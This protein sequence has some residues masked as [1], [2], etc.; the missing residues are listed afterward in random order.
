MPNIGEL[1]GPRV[2]VEKLGTSDRGGGQL[3]VEQ[4]MLL[5]RGKLRTRALGPLDGMQSLRFE[6]SDGRSAQ[7]RFQDDSHWTIEADEPGLLDFAHQ[8]E[9]GLGRSGLVTDPPRLSQHVREVIVGPRALRR[10]L[11]ATTALGLGVGT[12][13][14]T[15]VAAPL[16]WALVA[17]AGG[18]VTLLGIAAFQQAPSGMLGSLRASFE[19]RGW[20]LTLWLPMCLGFGAALGI[21][22]ASHREAHEAL[23]R[24]LRSD[25]E[26]AR[27]ARQQAEATRR[28]EQQAAVSAQLRR[29]EA[30]LG[31]K[32]WPEA[33]AAYDALEAL[34]PKH[35]ALPSVW[36]TLGP[37]LTAQAEREREQAIETALR[38]ARRMQNDP[39]V[40]DDARAV[41]AAWKAL[42]ALPSTDPRRAAAVAVV[43][44][45]ERCRKVVAR[46][47]ALNAAEQRRQDRIRLAP[48]VQAELRGKGYVVNV[49]LVGGAEDRVRVEGDALTA[50]AVAEIT[51]Q[52]SRN[53]GSLLARLQDH[54][55]RSVELFAG[56]RRLGSFTLQPRGIEAL[57]AELLS[58]M[59]LAERLSLEPP[60]EPAASR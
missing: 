50:K 19:R 30:A 28:A 26:Q 39:V 6:E 37:Q 51:E 9:A 40:C 54:G 53:P 3:V 36:A 45:L 41:A 33:K 16:G 13:M 47:L 15:Q 48:R 2:R 7:L 60:G 38:D 22:A 27:L 10:A 46:S 18:W 56:K 42:S 32:R 5:V 24:E 20:A 57:A 29:L 4:G 35:P 25:A 31:D 17:A 43:P 34:E 49:T 44:N 1:T 23:A 11:E 59:G 8:L 14:L 12:Q 21:Q 58:S 52:G 55:F